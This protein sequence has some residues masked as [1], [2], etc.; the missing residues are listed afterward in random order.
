MISAEK[1]S[2]WKVRLGREGS[3][4]AP[5]S[6]QYEE[7]EMCAV[8]IFE[9]NTEIVVVEKVVCQAETNQTMNKETKDDPGGFSPISKPFSI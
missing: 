6:F 8:T 2:V 3:R 5:H 1:K 7:K 9:I 4:Q